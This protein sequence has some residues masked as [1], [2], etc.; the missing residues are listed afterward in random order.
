MKTLCEIL[1][2][3]REFK[4]NSKAFLVFLFFVRTSNLSMR[5]CLGKH[6]FD[7]KSAKP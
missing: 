1:G 5:C 2:Y 6:D 3:L 4:Q 7:G